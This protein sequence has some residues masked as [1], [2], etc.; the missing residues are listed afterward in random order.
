M[1]TSI[2]PFNGSHTLKRLQIGVPLLTT[3]AT[4]TY[5]YSTTD[6][7]PLYSLKS[8][9]SPEIALVPGLKAHMGIVSKMRP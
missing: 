1:V 7:I 4:A 8:R 3:A 5:Q 6:V 2:K 9:K